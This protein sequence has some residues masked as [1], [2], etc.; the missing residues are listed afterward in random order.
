ML[1]AL[2]QLALC[3]AVREYV[4]ISTKELGELLDISQQAASKRVLALIERG[5]IERRLGARRQAIKITEHGLKQLRNEYADY[6]KIFEGLDRLVIHGAVTSGLGDGRYYVMQSRYK[7][8]FRKKLWFEPF[9]G[10]LNIKVRGVE[11]SKLDVLR[12]CE[13]IPIRGFQK[14]GHT[15]GDVKCFLAKI[16]GAEGAVLLP[17]RSHYTD[18]L[19]IISRHNLRKTLNIRDG[20]AVEVVISL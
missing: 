19:E 8:Q 10:T 3:G 15:F 1:K 9:E 4:T 18:T 6:I 5:D 11:L 16:D 12:G 13:G 17:S 7:E 2:K 14:A 20:D